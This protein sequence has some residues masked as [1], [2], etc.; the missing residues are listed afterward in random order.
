MPTDSSETG[1]EYIVGDVFEE[2]RSLPSR[3]AA[4]VCLDDAWSR[5]GRQGEFGVEYPTHDL[6][7]E[8][9]ATL[10]EVSRRV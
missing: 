9:Q 4:L 3:S 6:E 2:L 10:A 7:G 8:E 1:T 5:P